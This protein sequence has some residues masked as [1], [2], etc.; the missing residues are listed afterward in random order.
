MIDDDELAEKKLGDIAGREGGGVGQGMGTACD[1]RE[2]RLSQ[3]NGR[4]ATATV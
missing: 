3:R 2:G 4:N 1:I